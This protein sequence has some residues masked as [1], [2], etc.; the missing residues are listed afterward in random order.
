MP[1]GSQSS[2]IQPS[3]AER[4]GNLTLIATEHVTSH[5]SG[6]DADQKHV[7]EPLAVEAIGKCN[8]TLDLIG[9]DRCLEHILHPP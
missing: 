5:R 2:T 1:V 7:V 9:D 6:C 8:A 3:M 4:I